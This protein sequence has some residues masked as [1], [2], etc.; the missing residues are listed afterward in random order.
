MLGSVAGRNGQ[1]SKVAFGAAMI[2]A[3]GLAGCPSVRRAPPSPAEAP[4][5]GVTPLAAGVTRYRV[6]GEESL[7]AV[8]AYRGGALATLGHNHVIASRALSGVIDLRE[9]LAASRFEL[10][11]P[12]G[13]FE[14]DEPR[15]RSGR[16]ESFA[17]PV[18]DSARDG[19][20]RNLLGEDVLDAAHFPDLVARAVALSGG[21]R[22]FVAR[23]E[24]EVRG[25]RHAVDV[26]VQVDRP[27]ADR[28]H[29]SARFPLEQRALGLTPFSVMLGALRVEDRLD[30]ELDLSAR[31]V[32]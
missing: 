27:A 3:L 4:P 14:V 16:G 8:L 30:V 6:I 21:P 1:F 2:A 25:A 28:L 26:P 9:P 11:L 7:L 18:P 12:V 31:R 17:A 32:P 13:S 20:R 24:F 15:L 22:E 23:V 10:R 29:V 5:A 19:T